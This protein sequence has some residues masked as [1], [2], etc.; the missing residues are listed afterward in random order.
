MIF[1]SDQ[2]YAW[3]QHGF[4][5]KVAAYDSNIRS[6]LIFSM[7]GRIPAGTT[8][9]KPVGGVDIVPTIFR[10]AGIDT[11][12]KMHGH[13]LTP[14]LENPEA[15]WAH[16]VLLTSTG[17]KFGS[18]TNVIPTG[19]KVMHGGAPWYVM[20][21]SGRYKY[22]RPMLKGDLEELYDL[23]TDPDELN[24]LAEN[25][26]YRE[27]LRKFRAAAIEQ[28]R[29]N[30]A[31]FVENLPP[32][33]ETISLFDGETLNGWVTLDGE[34]V[35]SGWEVVDGAIHVVIS[36]E[37][38][39]HIKTTRTF[40]NFELEFEWRVAE[41]GNSGVKY[42]TKES[43]SDR[44]RAYYGC[45][46]QLLDDA[47]HKN[48]RTATK[49]AGSLYDLYAPDDAQKRLNPISD[50]N[51][52]KIILNNGR[53][54]HW[55]NGKKIVEATIGSEDWQARVAKSK[56]SSVKDFATGP[57]VILLQEHLSE[58]WFKNIRITLLPKKP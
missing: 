35:T 4:R 56:V 47:K 14:L 2:G 10:F 37:R 51:H 45:E 8:C 31:G 23:E 40:E 26:E 34:P 21:R 7:P 27:Q 42:L 33:R 55:L 36:E 29:Q 12:W 58:A 24:N 20:L 15:E 57:G 16:P 32:I 54:E 53:I 46:Y 9:K 30:D 1:T 44:G 50:F 25:S 43:D 49:T 52:S 38:S 13:D 18:D 22:V 6:P 19:K 39:G 28:L 17:S 41:G 5:H 48:G 11:P 3:G